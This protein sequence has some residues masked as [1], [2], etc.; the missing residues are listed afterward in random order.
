M[1]LI[2]WSDKLSVKIQEFDNQHQ[3]LAATIN[4]LYEAMR[5]T[6]EE[7]VRRVLFSRLVDSTKQHFAAEERPM[8][9]HGYGG[10]DAHKL[11]HDILTKQVDRLNTQLHQGQA[12]LTLEVMEFLKDWLLDHIAQSDMLYIPFLTQRGIG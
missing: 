2:E 9:K 1:A 10:Y 7:E 8:Q 11:Q 6:R 3:T 12:V 5:S 4:E